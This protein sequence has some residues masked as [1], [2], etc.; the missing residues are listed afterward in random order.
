[1]LQFDE[2]I[3][4][5]VRTAGKLPQPPEAQQRDPFWQNKLRK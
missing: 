3:S 5:T 2:A 4:S 1:M